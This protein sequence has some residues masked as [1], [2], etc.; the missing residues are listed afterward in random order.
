M[1][2]NHTNMSLQCKHCKV[3]TKIEPKSVVREP[4]SKIS[5]IIMADGEEKIFACKN[6]GI[7]KHVPGITLS[8]TCNYCNT[9]MVTDGVEIKGHKPD[10]ILP[11]LIEKEQAAANAQEYAK[12][13]FW[14]PRKFKKRIALDCIKSSYMP[15]V[16]FDAT[17]SVNYSA[18][19]SLILHDSN[20]ASDI[21]DVKGH[22]TIEV[23]NIVLP[24]SNSI[25]QRELRQLRPFN[26]EKATVYDKR[27]LLGTDS[28]HNEFSG[29]DCLDGLKKEAEIT[30]HRHIT[31]KYDTP[32]VFKIRG[33]DFAGSI[34]DAEY[35]Y[36]LLPI[37]TVTLK[38][39]KKL[40]V[41]GTNGNVSGQLPMTWLRYVFYA[42]ALLVLGPPFIAGLV[43]AIALAVPI[44]FL[45][46]QFYYLPKVFIMEMLGKPK[47]IKPTK[48]K[49]K[50]KK[51]QV[52][53]QSQKH[54]L[55]ETEREEIIEQLVGVVGLKSLLSLWQT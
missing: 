4:I 47:K 54:W 36:A 28:T 18:Q 13:A 5:T 32:N 7:Q 38:K 23:R 52:K 10:S 31:S 39:G 14:A 34:A 19:V 1:I 29:K 37:Y 15:A 16:A 20:I 48:A 55:D 43:A 8:D 49:P 44:I 2:F 26:L 35:N 6:C 12:H 33:V 11:F 9:S 40:F 25:D 24:A 3:V 41:N 51:K 30:I 27:L 17:A 21:K 45:Y 22:D 50:A 42:L 46:Y 53:N